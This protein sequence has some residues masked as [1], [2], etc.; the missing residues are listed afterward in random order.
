MGCGASQEACCQSNN[1]NQKPISHGLNLKR[2]NK[3]QEQSQ[4][5]FLGSPMLQQAHYLDSS[6]KQNQ[7]TQMIQQ[8][9]KHMNQLQDMYE[10]STDHG[11]SVAV[12]QQ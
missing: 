12:A 11:H 9:E 5:S 2:Y 8:S 3:N 1:V 4:S 10:K 7:M 6:M